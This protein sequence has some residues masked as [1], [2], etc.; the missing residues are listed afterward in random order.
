MLIADMFQQDI[1]RKINGVIKVDQSADEVIWNEVTEY[2]IT[3]ELN[4]HFASFFQFYEAS[5]QEPTA[6]IGVWISGFFGSGKSH[7]LKMLSYLLSNRTISGVRTVDR[8]QGKL[9]QDPDLF[10][11]IEN[12]TRTPAETILFNIDIE[13]VGDKNRTSVLRVFAKMFYNHLGFYGENLKVAM[14]ERYID[15]CGKTEEFR[16]VFQE[17]RGL[18]WESQRRVFAFNGRYVVPTLMEV[19]DMTERDAQAWFHDRTSTELSIAMLVSDIREYVADRPDDFRLIFLADEVGQFVGTDTSML[20]NLQSLLEKIG[21]ECGGKVW[22]ICTGQ[23]AIDEIIRVRSDEFSRIQARFHTQLSL[24][25][26]SVDE[27]IQK[28]ILLKTTKADR[29]L[30][31][32]YER[33]EPALRNLFSFSNSVLDIKG[34]SGK[35]E[36]A[37]DYPFVPYQF[38]LMQKVFAEIRRH[39]NSGKHLSGGERS[40]L[41]GFQEAAQQVQ[42]KDQRALVPFYLFYDTVH[43]FLDSSIR[44][45]IERAERASR[46]HSG[47]E[48]VD[49]DILKLLYLIRYVNDIPASLD[50][51]VILMADSIHMD[52]IA[53]REKLAASLDRLMSQN[54]IT[55]SGDNLYCFLTDEEQD[56]QRE[57]AD[58]HVDA[59]S[60]RTGLAR[61][62]FGQI[63]PSRRCTFAGSVFPFD[64]LVDGKPIGSLTG[65]MRLQFLTTAGDPL[66]KQQA[67][68][69]SS[70]SDQ[71]TVVL[72]DTPYYESLEKALKIRTYVRHQNVAQLP[73]TIQD[74]IAAQ[75]ERASQYEAASRAQLRQ[76]IEEG[77]FWTNGEKL[78]LRRGDARSLLDQAM[79]YLVSH[80]YAQ[81][82]LVD[83]PISTPEELQDILS[84]EP[85]SFPGNRGAVSAMEDFLQAQSRSH[86]LTTMADLQKRYQAIPYGWKDLDVAA[87]TALLLVR[88]RIVLQYQG[89]PV[90]RSSPRLPDLLRRKTEMG[91]VTVSLLQPVSSARIRQVRAFARE[92]FDVMDVPFQEEDLHAFL[93]GHL[94]AR[95]TNHRALLARYPGHRY[96]DRPLVEE[97]VHLLEDILS[98]AEDH[99]AFLEHLLLRRQDLEDSREDMQPVESFFSTQV[100]LFDAAVRF[101]A[102]LEED[103]DYISRDPGAYNALSQI[104][105]VVTPGRDSAATY[106]SIPRLPALMATV[107]TARSTMLDNKREEVLEII[108]Q[109]M[110]EI[111]C[112]GRHSSMGRD[113]SDAADAFFATQ[114]QRV[115]EL[116]SLAL[117]DGLVPPIWAY[118]DAVMER[119]EP[120]APRREG[121][122]TEGS[123]REEIR[124]LYR[125]AV[126]PARTLRSEADIDAYLETV[127]S[128][129]RQL[130]NEC[131]GIRLS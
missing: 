53:R 11:L 15:Q 32:I 58:T 43:T 8:F 126:F 118:K 89:Q 76:A 52:K 121:A 131:D 40:M 19:L 72:G 90:E 28:R 56:I 78:T 110:E 55:R 113:L 12:S 117:L 125:Q 107:T 70:P 111:H 51:L 47:L 120:P 97:S 69:A 27:V 61:M 128:Q 93:V 83:S 67:R 66:E 14:L 44:N 29:Q 114:K 68:L 74:I 116:T 79:E 96:P 82:S 54:Y 7:F 102:E 85:G 59:D 6:D 37:M 63:Y 4:R 18:S 16:R 77:A 39:G 92:Y 91:K 31:R 75:Q 10:R 103:R 20:L 26:S 106:R 99:A 80:V 5:F 124:P 101:V 71:L 65:G 64:Q 41:S 62:L 22:V 100:D 94:S 36:F 98:Q 105:L 127:R 25:S 86:V 9:S 23:E 95:L 42:K 38:I 35:G 24:S 21:S 13:N 104:R 45:V 84:G 49:V 33:E 2:V 122:Q 119:M 73:R 129:M 57:I 130:L 1:N 88:R 87:V 17:K 112:A 30:R 34:Y 109:C 46:S 50:N 108:R 3:R 60:I 81:L 123:R 115:E 48:P